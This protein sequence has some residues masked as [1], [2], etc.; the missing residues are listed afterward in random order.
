M[1]L[2]LD[3]INEEIAHQQVEMANDEGL[4]TFEGIRFGVAILLARVQETEEWTQDKALRERTR[5]LME[6]WAV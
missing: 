5:E 1:S 4:T 2:T 3:Q 6:A